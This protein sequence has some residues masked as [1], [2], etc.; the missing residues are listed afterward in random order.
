[1]WTPAAGSTGQLSLKGGSANEWLLGSV[2][3][4]GTCSVAINGNSTMAGALACGTLSISAGA[5]AG[6]AVG[7]DYGVNTATVEA[8]LVE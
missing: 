6:T 5:G 3:W 1:M 4:T 2:D 7:G 8:V